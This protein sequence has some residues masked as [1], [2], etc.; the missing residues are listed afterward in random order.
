M[1]VSWNDCA[2]VSF[3][4]YVFRGCPPW[5]PWRSEIWKYRGKHNIWCF[6]TVEPVLDERTTIAQVARF[7]LCAS[8]I[9]PFKTVFSH[10]GL[11]MTDKRNSLEGEPQ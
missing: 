8:N 2:G 4:W 7:T 5:N 11:V 1:T 9:S 3:G 6:W 10:A